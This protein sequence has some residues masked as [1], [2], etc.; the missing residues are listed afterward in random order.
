MSVK[1]H[2]LEDL[3]SQPFD[4]KL[5]QRLVLLVGVAGMRELAHSAGQALHGNASAAR[6][7]VTQYRKLTQ[8]LLEVAARIRP[9]FVSVNDK[10]VV[11]LD[12]A[13][14]SGGFLKAA[15]DATAAEAPFSRWAALRGLEEGVAL[16]ALASLRSFL[17]TPNRWTR[18]CSAGSCPSQNWTHAGSLPLCVAASI[19]TSRRWNASARFSIST[20]PSSAVCSE[21]AAKA[22][23][24][25]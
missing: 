10:T 9:E 6:V 18:R 24:T 5:R 11:L 15:L 25:G 19:P 20:T 8:L 23:K 4:E 12:P 17:P 3:L 2:D 1:D 7:Y 14:G 22:P 13:A 16:H 21:S